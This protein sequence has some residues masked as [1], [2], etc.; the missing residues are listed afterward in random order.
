MKCNF[1][2]YL[3]IHLVCIYWVLVVLCILSQ[4]YLIGKQVLEK[5]LYYI[6][7]INWT[8]IQEIYSHYVYICRWSVISTVHRLYLITFCFLC[9]PAMC[10]WRQV[11][12]YSGADRL[13]PATCV[14]AVAAIYSTTA[15]TANCVKAVAVI[16]STTAAKPAWVKAVAAT[17]SNM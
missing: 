7:K 13:R 12:D 6:M 10:W 8:I 9:R 5:I 4:T 14:K 16:C 3:S 1:I 11:H 2:N 17:Y 15:G